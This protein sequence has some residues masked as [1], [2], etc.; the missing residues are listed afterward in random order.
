[1]ADVV[2]ST[3]GADQKSRGPTDDGSV[4]AN[5]SENKDTVSYDTHRKLLSE[6]KKRDEDYRAAQEEVQRLKDADRARQEKEA[7]DVDDVRKL[8]ELERSEKLEIKAKL[9]GQ[10]SMLTEAYKNQAFMKA[11]PGPLPEKYHK[12]VDLSEV[13]IDP[14]TGEADPISVKR[15][16]D[17]FMAE[18]GELVQI[19]GKAKIPNQAAQPITNM[20][21]EVWASMSPKDKKENLAAYVAYKKGR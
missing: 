21:D 9:D 2:T 10:T 13:I 18:F 14:T 1:M 17:K 7:K 6:K 16:T 8:L 15:A 3:S 12:M 20:S 5:V 4:D 19:P 11:L